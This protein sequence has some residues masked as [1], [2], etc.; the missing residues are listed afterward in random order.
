MSSDQRLE[1]GA[2]NH[3]RASPEEPAW[4][5]AEGEGH[6]QGTEYRTIVWMYFKL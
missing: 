5:P 1:R 3:Q 6:I 2:A 4:T